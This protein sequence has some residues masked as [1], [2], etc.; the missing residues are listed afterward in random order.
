MSQRRI[1]THTDRRTHENTDRMTTHHKPKTNVIGNTNMPHVCSTV[2]WPKIGKGSGIWNSFTPIMS[3]IK[4]QVTNTLTKKKKKK[5]E[6][7]RWDEK[8]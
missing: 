6:E 8:R 2:V 1:Y 4:R 5:R 7:K 3:A